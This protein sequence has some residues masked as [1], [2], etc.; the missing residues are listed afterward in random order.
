VVVGIRLAKVLAVTSLV[1]WAGAIAA[2][3]FLAYTHIRL[4]VDSIPIRRLWA[5]WVQ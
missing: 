5:P 1:C 4:M 2:G 3:R